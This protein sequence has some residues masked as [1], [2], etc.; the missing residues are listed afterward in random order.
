[1][2]SVAAPLD[3]S[4]SRE[5]H[6]EFLRSLVHPNEWLLPEILET[7]GDSQALFHDRPPLLRATRDF[8][9]CHTPFLERFFVRQARDAAQDL[10][11]KL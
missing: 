2:V 11:R 4:Y 8:V 9:V 1:M 3:E 5:Q 7:L 10:F 6:L